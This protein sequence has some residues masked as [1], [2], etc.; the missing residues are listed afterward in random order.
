[1]NKQWVFIGMGCL[2][3]LV[4]GL[5]CTQAPGQARATGIE[6]DAL[7]TAFTYQGQLGSGGRPVDDT[8][9]FEFGLYDAASLGHQIGISQTGTITVTEGLFTAELDFGTGAFDGEARWLA[10]RVRCGAEGDYTNLGR[11]ALTAAPYALHSLAAPWQGLVDVPAGFA[12]GVDDE[13]LLDVQVEEGLI[14]TASGDVI[15]LTVAFSGAGSAPTVAHSDHDHDGTYSPLGHTHPGSDI[16]SAVPTATLALSATEAPWSGLAGVPAGFADGVDDD[17]TYTG[18]FGLDL[19]GTTFSVVTS[20]IQS[21]VTGDCASGN[22]IRVINADG[23]VTCE[24]VAGGTGDITAVHAG[25]GLG[26]GGD[27]GDVTLDVVTSTVQAR[28]SGACAVGST[29]RAVNADGTVVCEAHDTRP[30]FTL[31]TVDNANDVRGGTSVAIGVDGL[32]LVAYVGSDAGLKVAHCNDTACTSATVTSLDG[33]M[34]EGPSVTIGSDGLGLISFYDVGFG[35]RV[36]HCNDT[37]CTSATITTLD[38]LGNGLRTSVTIGADGLGLISFC[39]LSLRVAHCSNVACTSATVSTLDSSGD[40]PGWSSSV[41]IGADGLGLISYHVNDTGNGDRLRVAH[42]N[43]VGCTSA[44]ITTLDSGYPHSVGWYT[45]VTTGADGLGLITYVDMVDDELMVAH[46]ANA[47]CTSAITTTLVSLWDVGYSSVTIGADRLGLITY[48]D[49]SP[50]DLKVAHCNDLACTSANI[51]TVDSHAS[52]GRHTSVTIGTDGLP[53]ISY[54]DDSN[55]NLK[56]AHCSNEFC[57]P[58]FRRR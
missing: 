19:S 42:C 7:G 53:L 55:D 41:T 48:F 22:A 37:A 16:T 32:G 46:C 47:T 25:Y 6:G 40:S 21:R 18:G 38:S 9:D 13:G 44:A 10:V 58:Y 3:L 2:V 14:R 54:F 5:I 52:V 34:A 49:D 51:T 27:I 12:D 31:T 17:T 28:V 33:S 23:S 56:V 35:L 43:D 8:C 50:N 20:T 4:V 39:G 26:G 29:I 36:A 45:S 1:M 15:T 57:I 30:G 11:Q 24:P